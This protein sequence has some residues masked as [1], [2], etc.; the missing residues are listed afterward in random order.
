MK[1]IKRRNINSVFQI[2]EV[3]VLEKAKQ[4][5]FGLFQKA[6][7]GSKKQG[8]SSQKSYIKKADET[9]ICPYCKSKGVLDENKKKWSCPSCEDVSV[10]VY[11]GNLKP[12]GIMAD[13]QTRQWRVRV[14][15]ELAYKWELGQ[16]K[17]EYYGWISDTL[18]RGN[19]PSTIANL[20]E[21]ECK[22]L[23]IEARKELYEIRYKSIFEHK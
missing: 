23:I 15:D 14:H 19:K 3:V 1:Q 22:K 8:K 2:N 20:N 11:S 10:G 7:G 16:T 5:I 6:K 17:S 12:L 13:T 9:P 21:F 18:K 4:G